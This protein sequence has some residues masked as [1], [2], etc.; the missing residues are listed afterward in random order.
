MSAADLGLFL[1]AVVLLAVIPGPGMLYVA[2]RTL[3]GGLGEGL[4][5]TAGTG[6]GGLV[7][8]LAGA[9]GLSALLMASAEA[10][11]MMKLLGGC[12]LVWLGVQAWRQARLPV[13]AGGEMAALGMARAFRAW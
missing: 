6:L 12:Y 13:L 5:S 10:F 4:A 3:A 2:A 1:A 9:A 7:H 8:V 11:T